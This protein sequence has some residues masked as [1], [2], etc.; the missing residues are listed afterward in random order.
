MG[1]I[2]KLPIRFLVHL[3]SVSGRATQE[4]DKT[5]IFQAI[6]QSRHLSTAE[7]QER[8]QRNLERANQTLHS[9]LAIL[10]W[11]QAMHKNLLPKNAKGLNSRKLNVC[12][13]LLNDT[14]RESLDLSLAQFEESCTDSAVKTLAE[15]LPPSLVK[16]KLSFE[17]CDR[18][19]DISLQALTTRL[20]QMKLKQ[21][22]LDFVGC[23]NL[24]DAGSGLLLDALGV[25][26]V[27][28]INI[29]IY[30]CAVEIPESI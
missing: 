1:Y 30:I 13:A 8:L 10:A 3:G 25:I 20:M 7:G 26:P 19:T 24:T 17:G 2:F 5:S 29:Y 6:A 15:S 18:L 12:E 27:M 22:H 11:P 16:L 9:T 21:L 14:F 23:K 4:R 28:E